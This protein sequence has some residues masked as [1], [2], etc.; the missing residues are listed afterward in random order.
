MND[1]ARCHDRSSSSQRLCSSEPTVAPKRAARRRVIVGL[2]GRHFLRTFWGNNRL[3]FGSLELIFRP[4]VDNWSVRAMIPVR[5]AAIFHARFRACL[6]R[7][8]I[9]R[10][11]RSEGAEQ[12]RHGKRCTTSEFCTGITPL[13]SGRLIHS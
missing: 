10:R 6:S 4:G 7:G 9:I 1:M 2:D 5:S 13:H 11:R 8:P 3:L 12:H